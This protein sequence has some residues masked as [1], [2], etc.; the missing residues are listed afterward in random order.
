MLEDQHELNR[1]FST[2]IK[3]F[4]NQGDYDVT[5]ILKAAIISSEMVRYDNWNGGIN[6]YS[7][8]IDVDATLFAFYENQLKDIEEKLKEKFEIFLRG[9]EGEGLMDIIIR[10]VVKHYIDWTSVS[11]KTTKIDFLKLLHKIKSIL[12]P[13]A[14]GGPK[15]QSV[16]GEYKKLYH[17]IDIIF[18]RLK[19][20]NPNRFTNLWEWYGHWSSGDLPTYQSRRRFISEM[21]KEIIDLIEKSS[22]TVPIDQPYEITGWE[23]VDRGVSEIRKRMSEADTEEQFQAIGLLSRETIISLAQEVYDSEIHVS[24]DEVTPSSTDAKRMLDAFL[25]YELGGSSNEAYRKYAKSALVL[26]NDLT[27]RRSASIHEASMCVVA[28]ISLV[29]IVKVITNKSNIRF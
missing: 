28:V 13:V 15:I 19:L 10:P 11:D 26:A 14:T 24:I 23:R 4:Q 22:E 21:Y 20:N 6:Y 25:S 29:N 3:L 27:H 1:I 17:E 7:I 2:T 16:N 5:K 8:Y 18:E 12:I 9:V